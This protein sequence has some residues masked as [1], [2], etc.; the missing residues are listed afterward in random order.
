M[1]HIKTINPSKLIH[2]NLPDPVMLVDF[3]KQSMP[4]EYVALSYCWGPDTE[5]RHRP[6]YKATLAT[7]ESLRSGIPVT[8]LPLT[9]R[10]AILVSGWMSTQY[11]WIDSLCIVQDLA[12]DWVVEAPK[13]SS[14]YS[15]AKFTLQPSLRH[16]N[17]RTIQRQSGHTSSLSTE[18]ELANP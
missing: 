16:G 7:R 9:L 1:G 15:G 8:N 12:Q 4:G 18:S 10:D 17:R 2:L 11:I 13:M 5:L 3:D 14:V 6:P